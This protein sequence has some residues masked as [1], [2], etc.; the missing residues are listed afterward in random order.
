MNYDR[1]QDF[2]GMTFGKLSVIKRVENGKYSK[3][4]YLCK[5]SCEREIIVFKDN[6]KRL[7]TTQCKPCS[8][9]TH[10]LSK[11]PLYKIWWSMKDRCNNIDHPNYKDYGGRGIT[12]CQYWLNDLEKFIE[13]MSPSYSKGLSL[14]R[15][16]ND[17][18]YSRS[19]CEWADWVKQANN[20]RSSVKILFEN[21][22]YTPKELS[23]HLGKPVKLI[24]NR[25]YTDPSRYGYT[26]LEG[27]HGQLS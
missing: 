26:V 1:K 17:E 12:V 6:L 16:N 25:S 5:C 15:I 2:T 11:H 23:L 8:R 20:K 14:E 13:D 21:V 4:R 27:K 19:N 24:Y 7:N 3:V 22:V 10:K 18:G 9:E